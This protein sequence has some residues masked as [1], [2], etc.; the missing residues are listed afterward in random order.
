[1]KKKP[2]S[3]HKLILYD[4]ILN[5][6]QINHETWE[7]MS[8]SGHSRVCFTR[9]LTFKEDWDHSDYNRIQQCMS[10]H[11]IWFKCSQ[12]KS[13]HFH[14]W[15]K[16]HSRAVSGC[17]TWFASTPHQ[18]SFWSVKTYMRK[19]TFYFFLFCVPQLCLWGSPFW[20]RF[21]HMWS[22]FWGSHIMS[23]WMENAGC[24]FVADIDPSRAC[25]SGSFESVRWNACVHRLDLSLYSR[26]K[27]FFWGME[28]ERMSTPRENSPLPE[29][30]SSEEDQTHDAASSR[31]A[32]PTHYQ[33][34]IPA[35]QKM[36]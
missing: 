14:W 31:T 9:K 7:K 24:V 22:N 28:S 3:I 17:S 21:V 19:W 13:I 4:C 32:S 35:P 15:S 27:E 25:M 6:T 16:C 26:L 10:S 1:M 2:F 29:K 30:F 8:T 5:F 11:P 18:I 23:S 34:A 36:N 20:V 12:N 33:W